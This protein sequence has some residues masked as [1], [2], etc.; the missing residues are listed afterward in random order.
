[1]RVEELIRKLQE[2]PPDA[3]VILC[4]EMGCSELEEK[5]ITF[6]TM[7]YIE[8]PPYWEHHSPTYGWESPSEY[9]RKVLASLDVVVIS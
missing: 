1:M 5:N 2:F 6:E 8:Y 3:K 9:K 7:N 4:E